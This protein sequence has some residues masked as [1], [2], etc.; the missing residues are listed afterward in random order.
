M[1]LQNFITS[2]YQ[3]DFMLSIGPI[4]SPATNMRKNNLR[5]FSSPLD[6]MYGYSLETVLHLFK[7][8]FNDFFS[9]Y[10]VDN[11]SPCENPGMLKVIDTKN[12]IIS[13][14]HFPENVPISE[15]YTSFIAKKN[16][17]VKRMELLLSNASSIV[18]V[19][20]RNETKEDLNKFL[21]LFSKLYP[22][23]K[24]RLINIRHDSNMPYDSYKEDVIYENSNLSYVEYYLNDTQQGIRIVGGNS[25]IWTKILS[26]YIT[27]STY[28]KIKIWYKLANN[29]K[30]VILYGAGIHCIRVL[31]WTKYIGITVD[32]IAVASLTDNPEE[33]KN[34]PVRM[35]SSYSKDTTILICLIN[36]KDA[37]EV[38]ELLIN[39]GYNNVYTADEKLNIL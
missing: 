36:N 37:L 34:I 30:Q 12:N 8:S 32:G 29:S 38:K 39:R 1:N 22:N 3:C 6:W 18:L 16:L 2:K 5:D 33:I 21:V 13:I 15:S 19:S 24:I 9:E 17:R 26:N 14:H 20:N 25:Y 23:L 11:S 10:K 31:N 4:C 35:Y 28:E 27:N 7:T